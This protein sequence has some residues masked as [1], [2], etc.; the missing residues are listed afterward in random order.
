[1]SVFE[2]RWL[3]QYSVVYPMLS[4][5]RKVKLVLGGIPL[6]TT[7]ATTTVGS[8]PPYTAE[9]SSSPTAVVTIVAVTTTTVTMSSALPKSHSVEGISHPNVGV[10]N[11]NVTD[12]YQPR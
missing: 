8:P 6:S 2:T 4:I 10:P 7:A 5:E 12:V 11:C 9:S 3:M 1:M